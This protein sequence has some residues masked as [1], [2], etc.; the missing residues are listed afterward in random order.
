MQ[1]CKSPVSSNAEVIENMYLCE[2]VC[3]PNF[4]KTDPVALY[5]PIHGFS[6]ILSISLTCAT[7]TTSGYSLNSTLYVS[8]FVIAMVDPP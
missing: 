3:T 7:E 4:E 2:L 5:K 8:I 6:L 1:G